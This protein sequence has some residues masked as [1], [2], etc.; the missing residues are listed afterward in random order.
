MQYFDEPLFRIGGN[1]V[2][3]KGLIAFAIFFGVGLSLAKIFQ[4]E[5]FRRLLTRLK[6]GKN[7]ASIVP[8]IFG[9][10]TLIFFTVTA[11][12]A[13]GVPLAWNQPLPGISLTL[14]QIFLLVALLLGVFWISARTKSFLFNRFLVNSGLDRSLQYAIAQIVSNIVLVVGVFIVLDNAG[15][16]LGTL[17][18]FAGA[19]GVGIGFGLQNIASNFISGLV[20][21]AERPI[22]IG[23]RVEVAGVAGQVQQIRARSTVILTNDNITMIVPNTKFIDS[24]VT[25]WTYGDPRVRFRIPIGV[26]YGSDLEK[27]R[28]ALLEVARENSHVLPQPEPTVFLETFGESSIN[29]E[30]VVWSKEMSY[31]P[32]RFRSD[33]NFAIAQK[34]REAGI[35]IPGPQRDLHFRDGVV[36]VEMTASEK[37]PQRAVADGA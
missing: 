32:R 13:A 34:L 5:Q 2:T 29:L 6:L 33:L 37:T 15:I 20:I 26:A 22:T 1:Y 30:L 10:A 8:T 9:L 17:T 14:V 23:D 12:N 27:V 24:P 11:I 35:E 21:L 31:R 19:V 25:N 36:R 7:F 18:V 16:H 4:S 3:A 28:N